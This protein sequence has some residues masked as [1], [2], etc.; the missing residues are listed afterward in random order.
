MKV[1]WIVRHVRVIMMVVVVYRARQDGC[2][3]NILGV[4][5]RLEQN[6]AEKHSIAHLL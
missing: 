2:L 6:V 1:F 5:I 4:V 3:V